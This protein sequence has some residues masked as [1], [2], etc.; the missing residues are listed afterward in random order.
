MKKGGLILRLWL[1]V[2][3]PL[4]EA[5]LTHAK[6]R[7]V[8][9]KLLSTLKG[10]SPASLDPPLPLPRA[11]RDEFNAH[12]K[13]ALQEHLYELLFRQGERESTASTAASL[14]EF[15]PGLS[16]EFDMQE[17]G[18]DV[19]ELVKE[20]V[21]WVTVVP[22]Q[23][24]KTSSVRPA[25]VSNAFSYGRIW[26]EQPIWAF[27][28]QDPVRYHNRGPAFCVPRRV[29]GSSRQTPLLFPQDHLLLLPRLQQTHPQGQKLQRD[30]L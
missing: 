5:A 14:M 7:A 29:Q 25:M 26:N 27:D 10:R 8:R 17:W 13:T 20:V 23:L 30:Y 24:R 22:T 11:P 18:L 9:D 2:A 15:L 4:K 21:C 28:D 16:E 1:E 12:K 19:S 3:P 6:C